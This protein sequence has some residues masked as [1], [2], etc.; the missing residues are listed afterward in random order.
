MKMLA[1]M[2]CGWADLALSDGDAEMKASGHRIKTGCAGEVRR[3]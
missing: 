1:C 2:K 3:A